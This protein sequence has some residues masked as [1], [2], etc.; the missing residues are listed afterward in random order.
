MKNL[1]VLLEDLLMA[2]LNNEQEDIASM[3]IDHVEPQYQQVLLHL[4]N[5]LEVTPV[6][7]YSRLKSDFLKEVGT[8]VW[9]KV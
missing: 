4:V 1:H 7:T 5:N 6:T 8:V 3:I 2:R 9:G